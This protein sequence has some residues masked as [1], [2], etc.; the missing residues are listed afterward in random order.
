MSLEDIE[1]EVHQIR[2]NNI[3]IGS[4]S[5]YLG[6]YTRFL[7]WLIKNKTRL[8]PTDFLGSVNTNDDEKEIRNQLKILVN[9]NRDNPPLHFDQLTATAFIMWLVTL[10]KSDGCKLGY[11]S[12]NTHRASLFKLYRDYSVTMSKEL[13]DELTIH[14]RGLK[15]KIAKETGGGLN[16]IKTGK[17]PM[18]FEVYRHICKILQIPSRD[19]V[20]TRTFLIICWG[21]MCRAGCQCT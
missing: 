4:R 6:S 17:D 10:G 21:L 15:R 5:V 3:A 19:A 1:H 20:F 11:S 16:R 13:G 18:P 12:Y 14:F 7:S 2:E 9:E 8:I